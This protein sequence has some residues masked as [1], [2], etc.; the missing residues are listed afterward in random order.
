MKRNY[1]LL[2]LLALA[3]IFGMAVVGCVTAMVTARIMVVM[4]MVTMV[5]EEYKYIIKMEL[6][7]LV[8]IQERFGMLMVLGK[9]SVVITQLLPI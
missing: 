9:Q 5:M 2:S 4:E 1:I 8:M 3:L 7:L 6:F